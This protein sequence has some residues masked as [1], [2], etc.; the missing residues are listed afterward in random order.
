MSRV[1]HIC[2]APTASLE[3]SQD[4]AQDLA[5]SSCPNCLN[6]DFIYCHIPEVMGF[7]AVLDHDG[8][9]ANLLLKFRAIVEHHLTPYADGN[10]DGLHYDGSGYHH[11]TYYP[12]YMYAYKRLAREALLQLAGST[13]TTSTCTR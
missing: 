8:D 7:L 9:N 6:T 1:R 5:V 3:L 13:R 4:L 11:W 10:S 12:G 2:A